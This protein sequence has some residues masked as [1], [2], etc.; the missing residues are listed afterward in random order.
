MIPPQTG[1]IC[2]LRAVIGL[3]EFFLPFLPSVTLGVKG[4]ETFSKP[5]VT[6]PGEDRGLL[7][8][9]LQTHFLGNL[10]PPATVPMCRI[11]RRVNVL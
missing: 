8:P 3:S 9:G 6:T 4:F 7:E 11:V 1:A 5:V 2:R 10:P